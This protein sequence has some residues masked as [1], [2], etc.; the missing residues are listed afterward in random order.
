MLACLPILC[1]LLLA[2]GRPVTRALPLGGVARVCC[3]AA[4]AY[5]CARARAGK[6]VETP[7]VS[8]SEAGACTPGTAEA[9]VPLQQLQLTVPKDADVA[10][11]Q[12]VLR[13]ADHSKWY[14]DGA[15]NFSVPA[16][17]RGGGGDAEAEEQ[18]VVDDPL[19]R[20]I[21]D[22]ENTSAWTLMH[23]CACAQL[24]APPPGCPGEPPCGHDSGSCG[25]CLWWSRVLVSGSCV[26]VSGGRPGRA[27]RGGARAGSTAPRT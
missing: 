26:L 18:P 12:F 11:V 16:A 7:F 9:R 19:V 3:R 17:A 2:S 15:S 21:I 24:V 14:R 13:S 25:L 5:R 6:A 27:E 10:N 23:R 4:W 1:A 20:E 8:C 22:A